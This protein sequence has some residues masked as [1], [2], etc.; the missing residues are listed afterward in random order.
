MWKGHP[1][2]Q[3]RRA[4]KTVILKAREVSKEKECL[5]YGSGSRDGEETEG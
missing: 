3:W 4:L 5:N 1:A 2:A